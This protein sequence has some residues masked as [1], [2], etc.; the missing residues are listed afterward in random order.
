[1]SRTLS[2][3]QEPVVR[4]DAA[5]LERKVHR[6]YSQVNRFADETGGVEYGLNV[7]YGPPMP[8]PTVMVV[9]IQGGGKDRYR[10]RTW[11][12]RL[13]Y[14]DSAYGFGQRL[15]SDFVRA[16]LS[17]VLETATVATN[18]VFPQ[19]PTFEGWKRQPSAAAWHSRSRMWLS[20]LIDAMAPRVILTYGK[21][22]F[23]ELTGRPKHRGTLAVGR[24]RT[25]PVVG[26]GHLMQ[27]ATRNERSSALI[28]VADIAD[29]GPNAPLVPNAETI[30]AMEEAEAGNLR[31]FEDVPSLLD[32][33]NAED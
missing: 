22:A 17:E 16:G 20:V 28:A 2:R 23:E 6:I 13:Q 25:F 33:L 24:Y 14:L 29:H 30:A 19:W 26:C 9:S 21:S 11:P 31:R 10:Q 32:D 12:D 8:N 5:D 15:E 18:V 1:M 27:G 3:Y 4:T 7:L